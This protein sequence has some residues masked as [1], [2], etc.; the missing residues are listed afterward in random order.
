MANVV[1]SEYA[2][3]QWHR[4]SAQVQYLEVEKEVVNEDPEVPAMRLTGPVTGAVVGLFGHED[5]PASDSDVGSEAFVVNVE[6]EDKG[7]V[8]H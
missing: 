3:V 1:A 5:L 4:M 7:E 8:D 2:P 6:I